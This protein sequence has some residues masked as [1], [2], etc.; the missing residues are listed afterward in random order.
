MA[1]KVIEDNEIYLGGTYYPL[2]R[3]VQS[4][5]ASIYPAKVTIGDTTRDSNLRSSIIAWSDWRGGI[6][7]ER[8]QG[9]SDSD[10]AWHS[11]CNLRHRHHLVLA[12]DSAA[13]RSQDGDSTAIAGSIKFIQ[14]LGNNL[15]AS[16]DRCPYYYV[17]GA[18]PSSAI[19][20]LDSW[21]R[22]TSS[23][24]AYSFPGDPNHS[25]TVRMAGT[26]YIVVAHTDG[27]SYFSGS[28]A[29][30]DVKYSVDSSLTSENTKFFTFWDE[31]LWGIDTNGQLWYTYTLG[32]AKVDDAKLPV[33]ADSITNLFIGRDAAGEQI[34]YASTKTGL[35]AHDFANQRWVET[36]FQ[37]PFHRFNGSGSVRWRDS[38][39]LPSGLGIYKYINGSNNA[40]ITVMGPDRDDGVPKE[41]R[42][43]IKKLIGTH[44]EL[45]AAIDAT[46]A[47]GAQATTDIPWQNGS[48]SGCTAHSG[49]VIA[50]GSGQSS[51]V[52]W[53]DTGWETKWAA[54]NT[55]EA[56]YPVEHMLVS[57]AGKGEYRL[58]WDFK[59]SIYTQLIPFDVTNPSQLSAADGTDYTYEAS[60]THET[61]WFDAQQTEVDKLAIKLKVEVQGASSDETVIL[62][63]ALNYSETYETALTT[64]TSTT[65]GATSG[66]Q[67]F[68]LPSSASPVGVSFR[69]IK[70]RLTLARGSSDTSKSPDV[71]SLTLEYR[72]KLEAK[73]GHTV[74]VDLNKTYKGK[75][76][77]Q[78]RNALV[79][80]IESN[81]LQEFT[82]RDDGGGTR[83]YYVD[84]TSATGIEYTGYD[85]R[86]SSRITLVEP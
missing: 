45:L 70:F 60:G 47:P 61:P 31:R 84:V 32:G 79:T 64:I 14:N 12:A 27:Y 38:I 49:L 69:A 23:S 16:W 5:L 7:V 71:V 19:G 2:N 29:V 6:G 13:T 55:T 65:L 81:T 63:Y 46:T 42:G 22:V 17:E 35:Y 34:I 3:P 9:P 15:Y 82:F 39:Y 66:T 33:E 21:T 53:N 78:L 67:T 40:V 28:T 18:A 68:L 72:K 37:L 54:N 10:R 58:W 75:D 11:T 24:S 20:S 52:A 57:N 62:E 51:I 85:E 36:Q 44:T 4:V 74:E 25:I 1:N 83:N 30:S 80:S 50:P 43:T 48:T 56:G 73:Y 76:A 77:Q 26:D 8:M 59:G 86:G 41:Y